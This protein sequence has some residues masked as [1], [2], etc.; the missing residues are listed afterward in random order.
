MEEV[1]DAAMILDQT[2][3]S[4]LKAV[5][6]AILSADEWQCIHCQCVSPFY[7][8]QGNVLVDNM[9]CAFC[10]RYN[11]FSF[12]VPERIVPCFVCGKESMLKE[13]MIDYNSWKGAPCPKCQVF[14]GAAFSKTNQFQK[15]KKYLSQ[16]D[17]YEQK[18]R[19]QR[20][21]SG[22]HTP[23]F[24]VAN[25]VNNI[26]SNGIMQEKEIKKS[27]FFRWGIKKKKAVKSSNLNN[28]KEDLS[29][30]EDDFD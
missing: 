22:V 18:Q 9:E 23:S 15:M 10:R 26:N 12:N 3:L 29:I 13:Y 17:A 2:Q 6:A 8:Y 28:V 1:V 4:L 16:K 21:M 19:Q 24:P 25:S 5:N 27:S 11:L 30:I 7:W 14:Q 20:Q